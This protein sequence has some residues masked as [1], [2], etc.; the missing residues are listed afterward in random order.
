MN[1]HLD[2]LSKLIILTVFTDIKKERLH[3]CI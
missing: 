3:G 1:L 2:A